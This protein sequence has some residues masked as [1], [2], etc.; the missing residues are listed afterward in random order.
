VL[1]V[2][3]LL[4]LASY[5]AISPFPAVRRLLGLGIAATLLGARAIAKRR[6]EL[7]ARA[8]VRVAAG[9]GVALG[10]L[11]FAADLADASARH[12]AIERAAQR[13]T[14]LGADP[15][16]ETLWYTGH[17]ELQFYA[18]QAGLR[19]IVPG[20]S[21]LRPRDWLLLPEGMA[22]PPLSFPSSHF[23]Q[24]DELLATSASPWSTIPLYYDG[25]VP[26]RRQPA[27]QALLRIFRVTR[28]W[29]P[30]RR[31]QAP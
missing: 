29:V 2:W 9:F 26:L 19:A 31:S 3:L 7:E 11:Y 5:F 22:K 20:E 8:A 4:E 10:M 12:A 21:H 16:R 13:L 24:Q 14:Q 6:D 28:D 23:E 15:S 27:A 17:W 25:P 1:L 30:Q 18:Q